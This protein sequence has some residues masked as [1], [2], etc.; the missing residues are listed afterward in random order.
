MRENILKWFGRVE[1]RN[2][3]GTVK[4]IGEIRIDGK[5][6]RSRPKKKWI[7]VEQDM[8][9]CEVNKNMF[10]DKGEGRIKVIE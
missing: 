2:Y 8:R 9:A 1:R 6:R 4:K 10:Y 3:D 5:R 7:G